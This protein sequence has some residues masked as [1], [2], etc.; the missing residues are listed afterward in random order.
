MTNAEQHRRDRQE[1]GQ[2]NRAALDEISVEFAM[3]AVAIVTLDQI[4]EYL[5][6]RPIDGKIVLDD[7]TRLRI[8]EYRRHYGP[9]LRT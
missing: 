6:E 2:G 7:F 4:V 8:E 1:R 3:P 5:F 9:R